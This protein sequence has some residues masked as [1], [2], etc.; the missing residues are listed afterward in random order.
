MTKFQCIEAEIFG[1]QAN[2]VKFNKELQERLI[3]IEDQI[4]EDEGIILEESL[5]TIPEK[6]ND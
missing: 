5:D 4:S 2:L 1:I 3:D 6:N